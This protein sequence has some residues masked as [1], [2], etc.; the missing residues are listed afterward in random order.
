MTHPDPVRVLQALGRKSRLLAA[1]TLLYGTAGAGIQWPAQA[2]VPG[3]FGVRLNA[4]TASAATLDQA[5]GLGL[6]WARRGFIRKAVDKEAAC[7]ISTNTTLSWPAARRRAA[8]WS[9]WQ[10]A[11]R[12]T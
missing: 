8:L 12:H 11:H 7:I 6:Q 4:G 1:A 5:K 3:G 2:A 9:R 10:P